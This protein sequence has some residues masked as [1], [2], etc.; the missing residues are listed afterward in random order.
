MTEN[1]DSCVLGYKCGACPEIAWT[2]DQAWRARVE[3][4]LFGDGEAD[5]W[6]LF[7]PIV[8]I[9]SLKPRF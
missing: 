7:D 8:Y 2:R 1:L 6:V 5:V 9:Q 3:I 4:G